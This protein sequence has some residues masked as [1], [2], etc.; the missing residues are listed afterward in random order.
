MRRSKLIIVLGGMLLFFP[1]LGAVAL[2]DWD[3]INFAEIAREMIV[4]KDYLNVQIDYQPFWEKPPLFIWMQV[5]SMKLFG[6]NEF[7]ARFPNAICG[8]A[9]L[10]VIYSIGKKLY[11]KKMGI[12]WVLVYAGSILPFFYFKSGII[13]PWFNFIHWFT[14][15]LL[16]YHSYINKSSTSPNRPISPNRQIA[17]SSNRPIFLS[18][19]CIGLAILT[20][21]PVAF[22]IFGITGIVYLMS[23]SLTYSRF[24][25]YSPTVLPSYSH[26]HIKL[27]PRPPLLRRPR[28]NR[29]IMVCDTDSC[30]T[31]GRRK[32]F[33]H[34]PGPAFQHK[35]RRPWRISGISCC[36]TVIRCF[37]GIG[38][39]F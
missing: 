17:Q 6:I 12:I 33:H 25:S 9:T 24:P 34:L 20:K 37:P 26:V 4:T 16:C 1:F 3:E 11:S 18:G 22:L 36:R 2:F 23:Y 14:G 8:I 13:D 35:R 27:T 28:P 38:F 7:A 21:G 5:L 30:R 29:W 32:R 10:L 15:V 39:S 31:Y 19:L